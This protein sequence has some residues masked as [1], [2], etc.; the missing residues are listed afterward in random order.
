MT[1]H[2]I[3]CCI[4]LCYGMLCCA[5]LYNVMSWHVMSIWYYIMLDYVT[6]CYIILYYIISYYVYTCTFLLFSL[7]LVTNECLMRNHRTQ[8]ISLVNGPTTSTPTTTSV[9]WFEDTFSTG[10]WTNNIQWH[11]TNW[12]IQI[13]FRLHSDWIQIAFR[14]SKRS[15]WLCQGYWK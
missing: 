13:A 1:C 6:L 14:F 15:L 4:M 9:A 12:C 3:L 8:A 2:A 7:S 11:W 5:L 10:H